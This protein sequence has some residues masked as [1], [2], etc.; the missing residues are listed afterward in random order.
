MKEKQQ[1]C[2]RRFGSTVDRVQRTELY[3]QTFS[4]CVKVCPLHTIN[5]APETPPELLLLLF[6]T[7]NATYTYIHNKLTAWSERHLENQ[8]LNK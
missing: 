2:R 3:A 5:G 4:V 1:V 7:R 8:F 6:H